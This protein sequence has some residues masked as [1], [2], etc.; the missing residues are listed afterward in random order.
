MPMHDWTRVS[1]GTYH[2]FHVRW[3]AA[4][5]DAL[6][7]GGL[8]SGYFAM[9]EQRTEG[10][11]PD[12]VAIELPPPAHPT[13]GLNGS[14]GLAVA[15]APPQTRFVVHTEA[16]LYARRANRVTVRDDLGKVVTV[17]ELVSPGNKDTVNALRAFTT[18][19]AEFL[20]HGVNV[21]VIDP[22]PPSDRDPHGMHKAI[23]DHIKEEPFD[24]PADKPL[25]AAGY[26]AE[27]LTGYVEP[28]AVGDALPDVPLF[29]EGGRYV[30]CPFEASYQTTWG[31]MPPPIRRLLLDPPAS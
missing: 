26:S 19:L 20:Y 17:I 22:F 27:T 30:P 24:L 11:I 23:W 9:M 29:L 2:N 5:C 1:S 8:P 31:V 3:Q 21:V 16:D 28:F 14:G 13:V 4:L 18:K 7:A 10:Q 6:N 25:T 15:T 12:V